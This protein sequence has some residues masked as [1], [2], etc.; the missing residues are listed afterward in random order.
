M[1]WHQSEYWAGLLIGSLLHELGHVSAARVL[2]VKVKRFGISWKGPYIVREN[3]T[4][5]Q[6]VVIAFWGPFVNML[7]ALVAVSVGL[8]TFAD[9]NLLIVAINLLPIFKSSDG[10]RIC[11]NLK[12]LGGLPVA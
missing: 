7:L 5:Y 9:V 6:N 1:H 12:I 11:D 8:W 10:R 4:P 2:G 3:G